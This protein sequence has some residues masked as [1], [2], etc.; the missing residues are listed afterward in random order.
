MI[1]D[2]AG[3]VFGDE[4]IQTALSVVSVGTGKNGTQI[5]TSF[6]QPGGEFTFNP[7]GLITGTPGETAF[8]SG[9]TIIISGAT[10]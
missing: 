8:A 2:V 1:A 10:L 4:I 3:V 9:G 5:T 6:V 7:S